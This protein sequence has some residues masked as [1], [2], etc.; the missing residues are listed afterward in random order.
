MRRGSAACIR[1]LGG[2]I[3]H[4]EVGILSS[5][6]ALIKKLPQVTHALRTRIMIL[7]QVP[8]RLDE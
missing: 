7:L 2:R 5:F 1:V 8:Y 3:A 4:F 6:S